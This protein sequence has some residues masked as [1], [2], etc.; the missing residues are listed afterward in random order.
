MQNTQPLI[1]IGMPVYNEE[2][3]L[4][5]R[6]KLI[7]NQSFSD[8]EIIISDNGSTDKTQEICE[9]LSKKDKRINYIRHEVNNGGFWNFSFVEYP[10]C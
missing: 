10:V 9:E 3:V 4:R 5:Q 2:N 8:I 6:L 1:C 7:T